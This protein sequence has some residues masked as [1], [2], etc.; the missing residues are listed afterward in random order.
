MNA[1]RHKSP[2]LVYSLSLRVVGYNY[3]S[4]PK[5]S[6]LEHLNSVV[7]HGVPGGDYGH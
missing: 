3:F 4:I 2:D 6:S 7:V 1:T 5:G